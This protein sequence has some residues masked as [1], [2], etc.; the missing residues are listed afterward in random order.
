MQAE[1][2]KRGKAGTE[3]KRGEGVKGGHKY[4]MANVVVVD[5]AKK[6]IGIEQCASTKKCNH[7]NLRKEGGKRDTRKEGK[8][9]SPTARTGSA[10]INHSK[11]IANERD[12]SRWKPTQRKHIYPVSHEGEGPPPSP[13]AGPQ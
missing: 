7:K 2:T 11:H 5:A 12:T 8:A 10:R 9:L 13:Y 3:E 4:S 1:Q 6:K